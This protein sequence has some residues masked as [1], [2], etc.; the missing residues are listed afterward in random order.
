M[1]V[2]VESRL[3]FLTV[4]L[5]EFLLSLPEEYLI[6]SDGTTKAVF[7]E[8]MRGIVPDTVLKRTDKIS[9]Q[10]PEFEWLRELA[11]WA[12]RVLTSELARTCPLINFEQAE[13]AWV[14]TMQ[15]SRN[16]RPWMWR[17][18]NLVRWAELNSINWPTASRAAA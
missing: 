14:D 13:R 11:P 16:Y 1:A 17:V 12:N 7:R 6:S 4:D 18:L 8:A 15:T 9:F 10:T 5:V 2:S 3:P